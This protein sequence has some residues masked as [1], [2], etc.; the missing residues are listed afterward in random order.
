MGAHI[1]AQMPTP[2][3]LKR[4][5][6]EGSFIL[7]SG[8]ELKPYDRC[9]GD[10]LE[11][12][13]AERPDQLY[14]AE[15]NGEAW[16][17]LTYKAF[18]D[19]VRAIAQGLIDLKLPEGQPLMIISGNSI[20]HA[21]MKMAAMHIGIPVTSVSVAYSL[22]S[23]SHDRLLGIVKRLRPAVVFAEDA[24]QFKGALEA[25]AAVPVHIVSREQDQFPAAL[26]LRQLSQ[27]QPSAE[28]DKRFAQITPDTHAK[29]MLTSGSTG[30]PK[31]VVNTQ[32]MMCSN[33]QM[34]AQCYTFVETEPV[35]VLDWL[36]WSHT[37]GTNHNFNLVLRNGGSFYIDNGKPVPSLIEATVRNLREVR[38][39]LYFNVPKGYEA[40]LEYLRQDPQL[41]DEF[42]S[43][44]TLLFYAG[45]SLSQPVWDEL[46]SLCAQG[47]HDVFFTT[48]W[49][50]TETAPAI[51][52]VHWH[53]DKPGNIGIPMPG[54]SM[55]FV[56]NGSKLELRIKGPNVFTEYLDDPEI[57]A[58]AFDDMGFYCI[59]DAGRL[60]DP[61]NPSAGII[62][63]GRVSEDFKLSTGTW[64]CV[65]SVRAAVHKHFGPLLA[66]VVVTGHDQDYIGLLGF[67]G[68]GL[69]ALAGDTR[70]GFSGTE[71]LAQTA[72]R[73]ALLQ[74]L[75]AMAKEAKGS[76]QRAC[77]LTLLD[78]PASLDLG[79]VT[80][81]GNLNQ[82]KLLETRKTY[83]ERLYAEQGDD[84]VISLLSKNG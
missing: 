46:R 82:R 34:I 41:C 40:L 13:A 76:S 48:E 50:A 52:N 20:D 12:W 2:S 17:S 60:S 3:A 15:R 84:T 74:A 8:N 16:R 10:W 24:K 33:Q 7:E 59:G 37:F 32:R 83:V 56:P 44:L 38:P 58:Q 43:S 70:G 21:L 11:K 72:V 55:R 42:F 54:V 77:V 4:D 62:F 64:V 18:R 79:E 53:L 68:E 26:S 5:L 39:N 6:G 29:Y 1:Y 22:L 45:A 66:D 23:K 75:Q 14:I 80:D 69:R 31:V 71:L 27:T 78:A 49:G 36:P 81:K 47:G 65:A 63:D 28:V 25:C 61:N 30:H 73:D 67:P 9:V 51:T 57:T 35:R 19:E